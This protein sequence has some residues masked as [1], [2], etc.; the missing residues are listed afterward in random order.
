MAIEVPVA[1]L[2]GLD[3]GQAVITDAAVGGRRLRLIDGLPI[4]VT[5][6]VSALEGAPYTRTE[7]ARDDVDRN[8]R[9]LASELP[10]KALLQDPIY[11]LTARVVQDFAGMPRYR[12]YRAYTNAVTFGDV[13]LTHTDGAPGSDELTSLWYL[14][15]RWEP[16]W[17][18]ETLFY[19]DKTGIALA[20]PPRAGR[21]VV[22][23]GA[24][25]HAGRS[26][27]RACFEVRYTFA[28]K[29]ERVPG[30]V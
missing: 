3:Y 12:P 8:F 13:Q 2:P 17:G 28:I 9:H 1:K 23:D 24:I 10:I 16:D 27:G 14:C 25:P 18:G 21:L 7:R 6:Y 22:F 4:N 29:W 15:E 20:V 26:P 19:D 5:S 11:A 30:T